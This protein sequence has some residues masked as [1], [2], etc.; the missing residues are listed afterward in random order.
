MSDSE[1][2]RIHFLTDLE[3]LDVGWK[4]QR[5]E[6]AASS[7]E[8]MYEHRAGFMSRCFRQQ[9][10]RKVREFTRITGSDDDL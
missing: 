8:E 7:T 4:C 10:V 9:I 5:C 3:E 2:R 6:Y 1:R